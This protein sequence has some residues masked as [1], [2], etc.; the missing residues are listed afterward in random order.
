MGRFSNPKT[1]DIQNVRRAFLGGVIVSTT[2]PLQ[3][4]ADGKGLKQAE[5]GRQASLT[6]TTKNAEVKQCYNDIDQIV[7]KV[8]SSSEQDLKTNIADNEDGKYSV[9]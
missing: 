5:A 1:G 6:I 8:R 3:S 7:V 2:D 9:T 4:V